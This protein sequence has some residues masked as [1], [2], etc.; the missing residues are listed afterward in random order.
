[1]TA[2]INRRVTAQLDAPIVVFLI[3]IRINRWWDVRNWLAVF[4]VMPQIESRKTFTRVSIWDER[5]LRLS[6]YS[7]TAFRDV[8][9]VLGTGQDFAPAVIAVQGN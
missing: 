7:I 3:G 9:S 4:S 5:L 2:I 1:M 8:A 6:R